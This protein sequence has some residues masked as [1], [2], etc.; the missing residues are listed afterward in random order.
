MFDLCN[1]GFN[2]DCTNP[3]YQC[4]AKCINNLS[5]GDLNFQ[6]G[7]M[8]LQ[9]CAPQDAGPPIDAGDPCMNAC[10]HVQQCFGIDVCAMLGMQL[11]CSNPQYACMADCLNSKT[12]SQ[13]SF[14]TFQQCQT[15]CQ[16]T[17]GD[18]GTTT[19]DGGTTTTDG[20][21][22][23]AQACQQ[24]TQQ[25]CFQALGGCFQTPTCASQNPGTMTWLSCALNC[26]QQNPTPS[27]YKACDAQFPNAASG[28]QPVYACEC[29]KCTNE[30]GTISDPCGAH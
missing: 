29:Q 11:D 22:A 19:N 17:M 16:G 30:C 27:C 21:T 26:N 10:A 9:Q 14:Q 3:Q 1:Q 5:C 28:Y 23:S 18:G 24:C 12:C 8:C 7:Q 15:Q 13:I 2:L 20:G 6:S 25:G 4:T